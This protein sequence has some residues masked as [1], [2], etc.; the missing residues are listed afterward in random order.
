MHF[1]LCFL[2]ALGINSPLWAMAADASDP[3]PVDHSRADERFR[4]MDA[5]NHGFITFEEFQKRYPS[6]Q[7]P[8]FDAIDTNK[9]GRISLEEWRTFFEGHGMM[10]AMPPGRM[11][12]PGHGADQEGGTPLILPP[13]Q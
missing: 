12:P 3:Q 13:S 1:F 4:L 5:D 8:A 9:D 7:R 10:G 11:P 6:M 2:C